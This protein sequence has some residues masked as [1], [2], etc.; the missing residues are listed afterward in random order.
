[1]SALGNRHALGIDKL[2]WT[3]SEASFLFWAMLPVLLYH[4]LVLP[5]PSPDPIPNPNPNPNPEPNPAALPAC[6]WRI[7][8]FIMVEG[9]NKWVA[10][11]MT[12]GVTGNKTAAQRGDK[13]VMKPA[14]ASET[15]LC[16][17]TSSVMLAVMVGVLGPLPGWKGA[18]PTVAGLTGRTQN[19]A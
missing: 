6:S 8:P 11:A 10:P 5:Y 3:C 14:S 12:L 17:A 15:S 13:K 9:S 4:S 1:M 19:I 2:R 7:E 16:A 18:R